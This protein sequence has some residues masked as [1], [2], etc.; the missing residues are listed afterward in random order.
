MTQKKSNLLLNVASVIIGSYT[1]GPGKRVVIWIQGCTIGCPGCFNTP[2]QPHEPRHLIDPLLFAEIISSECIEHGCEGVTLTGGEPFQQAAALGIF[3][4]KIK[5]NNLTIVCFSG[6]SKENLILSIDPSVQNLIDLVDMLIAGPYNNQNT[7]HRTW[8]DD[9]DKEYVFLSDSYSKAD[10]KYD[11][12]CE[13]I[14]L[15]TGLTYTGFL[16]NQDLSTFEDI[17][18]D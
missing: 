14:F 16:T 2:M 6:Y 17:F 13:L 11:A 8:S 3:S 18:T 12:H 5:E 9:P 1:N 4:S 7:Y 15:E 10:L